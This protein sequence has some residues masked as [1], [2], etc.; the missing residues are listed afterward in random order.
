MGRLDCKTPSLIALNGLARDADEF[1]LISDNAVASALPELKKY[2][3][4]TSPSGG[5]SL[6]ALHYG[7]PGIDNN[8]RV[9]CFVTE[10]KIE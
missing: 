2:G 7:I 8:S 1:H 9:L 5:V 10:Q 3:L 6:A 4:K